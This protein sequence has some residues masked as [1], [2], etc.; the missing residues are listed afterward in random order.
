MRFLT[1]IIGILSVHCAFGEQCHK[2]DTDSTVDCMKV[3]HPKH[4]ELLASVPIMPQQCLENI[5]NLLKDVRQRI[6]GRRSSN[7]Q[8]M[9]NLLNRLDDISNHYMAK[10]ITVDRSVKQRFISA[11]TAVGN[12]MVGVRTCVWKPH[13]SCEKIQT[14]CSAVKSGLYADRTVTE[15]DISNFLIEFKTQF[16]KEYDS[17]I[18]S[19]RDVQ[20]DAISKTFC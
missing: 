19:I 8:C 3:I 20:S 14:C 11:Y 7:P 9:K 16:G 18:N 17:I 5:T 12:A 15:E 1:V 6:E 4:G 2:S 13:S 10:I